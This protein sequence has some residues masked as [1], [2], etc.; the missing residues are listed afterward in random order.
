MI[1][2]GGRRRRQLHVN[3]D[4]NLVNLIDVSFVLL[5]I[6]MITAPILQGGIEVQLPTADARPVDASEAVVVSIPREGPIYV[7]KA[8]VA[9][10]EEL[11]SVLRTYTSGE[12]KRPV[13]VKA[14]GVVPVQRL[15]DVLG[16]LNR[17]DVPVNL[18]VEPRPR[19]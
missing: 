4:I 7:E 1:G 18:A 9:S 11:E 14:D 15:T 17:L 12:K 10:M 5:I 19:R 2:F 16:V 3:A 8:K 6:F 13:M